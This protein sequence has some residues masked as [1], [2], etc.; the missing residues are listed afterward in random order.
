MVLLLLGIFTTSVTFLLV[1]G[2][3]ILPTTT[4]RKSVTSSCN[5]NKCSFYHNNRYCNDKRLSITTNN[6][7][8][9]AR[10][11]SSDDNDNDDDA[12]MGLNELQTLLRTAVQRQDYMEADRISTLLVYRLTQGN[13]EMG[14]LSEEDI[15]AR[16]FGMSWKGLGTAPWLETRLDALNYTFP[17]TIQINAMEAVNA[18]LDLPTVEGED[19]LSTLEERM[20]LRN[21]DMG[22]VVSGSTGSGKSLAYLVP[23]LSTL[24]DSFFVRQRL[25]VGAEERILG[26][27][28]EEFIA[29]VME[30]TTPELRSTSGAPLSSKGNT[31][32]RQGGISTGGAQS[33]LGKSD[34]SNKAN[35]DR[36]LVVIVVPTKELGVQIA[37]L[38]YQLVGGTLR[39]NSERFKG[40]ASMWNYKGPKGVRIGCVL[41]DED[42]DE[43]LKLQTDISIVMPKYLKRLLDEGD[44]IPSNLRVV[45]YD[46]ADLALEQTPSHSLEALFNDDIE[47]RLYTRL[48]FLV[49]ASVTEKLGTLAVRSRVLPERGNSFIA[50]ADTYSVLTSGDEETKDDDDDDESTGTALLQSN[51]IDFT[52]SASLQDLD[53]CLDPGLQHQRII[54]SSD[55]TRLLTLTRA[56]RKELRRFDEEQAKK[57]KKDNDD[58]PSTEEEMTST[59]QR[60]RVVVFFPTEAEARAAIEPIRDSMWNEHQVCV[61]LPKT[62]FAPMRIMEQFTDGTTNLMIATPNSVRG[63]DFPALTHVYTMYLPF[64][65][66][67]E[68]IHLAGRVGRVG[69]LGSVKGMNGGRV[70]TIMKESDIPQMDE[71]ASNLGFDITDIPPEEYMDTDENE[72]LLGIKEQALRVDDDE[73]DDDDDNDLDDKTATATDDGFESVVDEDRMKLERMR[74][75]LEDKLTLIQDDVDDDGNL[76]PNDDSTTEISSSM[77]DDEDDDDEDTSSKNDDNNANDWS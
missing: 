65:D 53:V 2:W 49:G 39:K 29:R 50:T 31:K 69:Q 25:R 14:S 17:T 77:G 63:L 35:V 66:P 51:P 5:K 16:K 47:E 30:V 62:G 43:G 33:T 68:Y 42:A 19:V 40:K 75:Y 72:I 73:D 22:I 3:M 57:T 8:N 32:P 7:M 9:T 1:E 54:T 20:E 12:N 67:R 6:R 10:Y 23:M 58:N 15:R 56:L 55:N 61:L 74:R 45:I 34:T 27:K 52:R 46:E 36:P 21:K 71:L 37:T 4:R 44:I 26:D 59:I 76:K 11:M 41:D 60:P 38:T 28:T 24:S 70:I 48:T 64:D 13:P 18:I